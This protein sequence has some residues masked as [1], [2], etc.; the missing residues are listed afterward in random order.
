MTA[1]NI[2]SDGKRPGAAGSDAFKIVLGLL[3][4]ALWIIWQAIR[5]ALLALLLILEPIVA[6]LLSALALLLTLTA[7][8][9]KLA[10]NRPDFPFFLVLGAGL[11]CFF[12]LAFYRGLIHLLSALR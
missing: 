2:A 6:L 8:F 5:A 9:W 10:S 4:G 12:A 11:A 1:Q 3:A 7:L